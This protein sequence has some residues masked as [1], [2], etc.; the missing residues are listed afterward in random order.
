MFVKADVRLFR[1]F[2][3]TQFNIIF[4]AFVNVSE[5]AQSARSALRKVYITYLCA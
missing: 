5:T 2:V 1:P 3:F 4:S